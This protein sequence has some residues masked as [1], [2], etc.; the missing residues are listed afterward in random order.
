M[1]LFDLTFGAPI[2]NATELYYFGGEIQD[3]ALSLKKGET[4]SFDSHFNLF[5]YT[6]YAEYCGINAFSL[7]LEAEGEY[8]ITFFRKSLRGKSQKILTRACSGNATIDVDLSQI[9]PKGY[10][11]FEISAITETALLGGRY[12]SDVTPS[13]TK[14]GIVICTYKRETFVKRNL[15]IV[16]AEMTGE[17]KDRLHV[18]I[19]DNAGTLEL[20]SSE[21]YTLVRNKNLGGSGG[22]TRGMIE[23]CKDKSFTHFLLMDDDIVFTFELLKRTFYLVSCLTGEHKSASVG[24]N[25]LTL[26]KPSVQHEHGAYF[27]KSRVFS[28][29]SGVDLTERKN[30]ILDEKENKATYNAW[31]YMCM[32]V[33]AVEKYGLPFPFFVKGDDIEYSIRSAEGIVLMNGI[34]V[35][36]QGFAVKS[37]PSTEYY[38]ARN[39]TAANAMLF[40]RG[41]FYMAMLMIYRVMR[42][43]SVLDYDGAETILRG[44]EDFFGGVR[45]YKDADMEQL[46]AE[47]MKIKPVYLPKAE[48]E[49]KFGE[50]PEKGEPKKSKV[51]FLNKLLMLLE[52]FLPSFF[53][54]KKPVIAEVGELTAKKV[55]FRKT[56]VVYDSDKEQGYVCTLDGKRRRKIRRKAEKMFFRLLFRYGKARRD[57]KKHYLELCTEEEWNKRFFGKEEE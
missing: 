49:E 46:N 54:R 34:S 21:C 19:I 24:G 6:K 7:S 51:A 20:P 15:D 35:W 33:S 40:G 2:E 55:K 48:L 53:F 30:L 17:W 52:N 45:F 13:E 29:N 50:M 10:I 27:K 8:E 5:P 1:V 9:P 26:E 28:I 16:A 4:A 38:A 36:H 47:L 14:I 44:Y 3:G 23:V 39:S 11:F 37:S 41:R 32:P 42:R 56:A 31:W 25:M 12:E 43:L 57:Y 22:F 18:F